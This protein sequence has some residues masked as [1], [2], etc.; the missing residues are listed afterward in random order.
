MRI[1]Q[2]L[3]TLSEFT[4]FTKKKWNGKVFRHLQTWLKASRDDSQMVF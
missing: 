4:L 3:S 1:F 2:T